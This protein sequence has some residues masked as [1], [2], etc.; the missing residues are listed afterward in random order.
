MA[1]NCIKCGAQ[2]D[3]DALFCD[4]CG[5]EQKSQ[6]SNLQND[7]EI[8]SEKKVTNQSNMVHRNMNNQGKNNNS[9]EMCNSGMG[10]AS[11]ILGIISVVTL[12]LFIIP[13]ILGLVFG[14][15]AISNKRNKHQIA[16][17]GVVLSIIAFVLF[18][19]LMNID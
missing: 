10:I 5:A 17:A 9:S 11:L 7:N 3:D 18:A 12:G 2:L 16:I 4:E 6:E 19:I 14:I 13:E 1:K 8:N 15:L